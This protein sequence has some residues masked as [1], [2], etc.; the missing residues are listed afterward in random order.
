MLRYNN[1]SWSVPFED[2]HLSESIYSIALKSNLVLLSACSALVSM[3]TDNEE[4]STLTYEEFRKIHLQLLELIPP[5]L[6]E[7]CLGSGRENIPRHVLTAARE[8][9]IRLHAE[10]NVEDSLIDQRN[11][12]IEQSSKSAETGQ[13]RA[14]LDP[15][16]LEAFRIQNSIAE[17]KVLDL[18]RKTIILEESLAPFEMANV[19]WKV[20]NDAKIE[21]EKTGLTSIA[22]LLQI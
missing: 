15:E 4:A 12:K 13:E 20:A 14:E 22:D 21:D 6:K 18:L 3:E 9:K 2:I 7:E 8:Y 16:V 10:M 1:G 19:R 11:T 17:E 5:P